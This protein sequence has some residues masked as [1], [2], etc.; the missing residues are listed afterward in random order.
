MCRKLQQLAYA[1]GSQLA[2]S[3]F[4]HASQ[5]AIKLLAMLVLLPCC[6]ECAAAGVGHEV[7]KNCQSG[8]VPRQISLGHKVIDAQG[9]ALI[10]LQESQVLDKDTAQILGRSTEARDSLTPS[11]QT[12]TERGDSDATQDARASG[13]DWPQWLNWYSLY[14][15]LSPTVI[16]W[17]AGGFATGGK[18][19]DDDE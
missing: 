15:L 10:A 1:L 8:T 5:L 2:R 7:L 14:L 17:L 4:I 13:D 9:C 19:H 16:C 12:V 6:L 11:G 3:G 18:R